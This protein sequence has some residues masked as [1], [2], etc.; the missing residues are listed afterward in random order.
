MPGNLCP[1]ENTIYSINKQIMILHVA[2]FERK[3]V[4]R[5]RG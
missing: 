3:M 1:L 2:K 5:A 4:K